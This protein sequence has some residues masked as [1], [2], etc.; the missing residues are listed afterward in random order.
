MTT[1]MMD[2]SDWEE[3][4]REKEGDIIMW[5][6]LRGD[7]PRCLFRNQC[8]ISRRESRCFDDLEEFGPHVSLVPLCLELVVE[9]GRVEDL[10]W[11][12]EETGVLVSFE[13][14]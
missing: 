5:R 4:Y 8:D 3:L 1:D 6:K 10:W 14:V 11:E 9:N 2:H 7:R 12:I 13:R